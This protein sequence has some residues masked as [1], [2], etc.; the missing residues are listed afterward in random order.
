MSLR[1]NETLRFGS[2]ETSSEREIAQAG[3]FNQ[4]ENSL[5]VG[6]F[7]DKPIWYSGDGGVCLQ[8]GARGGKLTDILSYN[9]C[10]GICRGS[11]VILDLRAELAAISQDQTPDGKFNIYWNPRGLVDLPK[12]RLNPVDYANKGSP[13]LVSDIKVLCEN[14]IPSSGSANA[15]Y[16]EMR[17][18]EFLEAICLTLVAI[19]SVLTLPDLY[20]V[21][22]LIPNGGDA[23][24]D[25]AFE[26][27][28]CGFSISQRVEE[29][30]A[31]AHAGSTSGGFQGILGELFKSVAPLS[32]PILMA[33]VSPPYNF[34]MSQLC[35]SDQTY[36]LYLMP[37][38]EFVGT[39]S[40][41]IKAIFVA[42]MIYKSRAPHAPRQT[43]II[44]EAAQ[45]S[46]FPLITKLF[47]YGAGSGIRPLAV[48]QSSAQM[49]QTG[50]DAETII[51]SSAACRIYFAIR[52]IGSAEV[53]SRMLGMQT[54]EFDDE[55]QQARSRHAKH[56]AL[57]GMFNGEDPFAAGLSY[58]HHKQIEEHRSQQQRWLRT[59]DEVLNT[60]DDKAYVFMDGLRH[61]IYSDRKP[62][63]RQKFM[64]GRYFPNPY[65]PPADHIRVKSWIGY[66][67][68]HVIKEPVPQKYAHFPQYR[69]GYWARLR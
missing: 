28:E 31:N 11:M 26:M 54:L 60:P 67:T 13:S 66:K 62:Y 58:A 43:W 29:E 61:P 41:V 51:P 14:L 47:T 52:D 15:E 50:P 5:L 3:L 56:Q 40:P 12:D 37:P 53:V 8:A 24:L 46:K 4:Q 18:R 69:D 39:W 36:Q 42:G 33:S 48:Y 25:F 64:T 19:N 32:D 2:A 21:I 63:F 9:I 44:D 23:W 38:A 27:S 34:S 59:P 68:L 10:S 17:G 20:N 30:I 6:F 16:F 22:N 7:G 55:L 35:E 49:R 1:N 65:H 57:Q 45:L